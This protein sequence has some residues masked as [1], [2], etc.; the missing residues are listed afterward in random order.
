VAYR[1]ESE[2]S[3]FGS[4]HEPTGV[5]VPKKVFRR[6]SAGG[7]FNDFR[8]KSTK[9]QEIIAFPAEYLL[10]MFPALIDPELAGSL[11]LSQ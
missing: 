8:P 5:K 1:R 9:K 6:E 7:R 10:P 4:F 3:C 11:R 2:T